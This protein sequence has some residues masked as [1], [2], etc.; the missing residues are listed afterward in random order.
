MTGIENMFGKNM[1]KKEKQEPTLRVSEEMRQLNILFYGLQ[2]RIPEEKRKFF[3]AVL[4]VAK[5]ATACTALK[6]GQLP[7]GRIALDDLKKILKY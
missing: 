4:F 1:E 7:A 3:E 5:L 2:A 6:L